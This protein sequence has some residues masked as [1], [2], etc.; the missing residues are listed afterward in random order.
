MPEQE[1]S[2]PIEIRPATA[3]DDT[4]IKQMIREAQLDPTSLKWQNFLIAEVD[5]KIAGIGQVKPYPGCEELGSLVTVREMRG[6]GVGG[7]II[8]ALEA[9]AGRPLYLLC[10]DKMEPYYQRFG[11]QTIS[12]W[13]A[14]W[15]LK[16]KLSFTLPFRLFGIR[17]LVMQKT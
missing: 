8:A 11:Y 15:P 13:D 3:A 14:P 4:T 9:R 12:W 10:V 7:A 2:P 6:K 17:V 1:P 5:G 16:T